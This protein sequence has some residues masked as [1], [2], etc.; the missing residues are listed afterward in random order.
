MTA[1]GDA[2]H[3]FRAV[4]EREG[5]AAEYDVTLTATQVGQGTPSGPAKG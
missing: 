4:Y 2:P 5:A 3:A 1:P